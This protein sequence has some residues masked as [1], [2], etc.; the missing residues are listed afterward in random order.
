MLIGINNFLMFRFLKKRKKNIKEYIEYVDKNKIDFQLN[1][2]CVLK[3]AKQNRVD[4]Q[5]FRQIVI[6]DFNHEV[7]DENGYML[8]L[9]FNDEKYNNS[10]NY[11][12][13]K[14]SS[15]YK[16]SFHVNIYGDTYLIRIQNKDSLISV[17]NELLKNIFKYNDETIIFTQFEKL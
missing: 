16:K 12:N 8:L 6:K 17:V 14:Q 11:S 7:K 15:L 3:Q 10:I 2:G 4:I 5:A 1:I 13:F 9:S